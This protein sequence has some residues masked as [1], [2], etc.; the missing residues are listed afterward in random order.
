MPPF[1]IN[2][3]IA[4]LFG[5]TQRARS[6]PVDA[7]APPFKTKLVSEGF[8]NDLGLPDRSSRSRTSVLPGPSIIYSAGRPGRLLGP[9]F[10][11]PFLSFQSH[12]VVFSQDQEEGKMT[13]KIEKEISQADNDDTQVRIANYPLLNR[14]FWSRPPEGKVSLSDALALHERNEQIDNRERTGIPRRYCGKRT[15]KEGGVNSPGGR[16]SR[17]I[18]IILSFYALGGKSC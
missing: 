2:A 13:E 17:A 1:P 16:D 4:L 8:L 3:S 11:S 12:R 9:H 6:S 10:L 5:T 7:V 15:G 14:T 18:Q